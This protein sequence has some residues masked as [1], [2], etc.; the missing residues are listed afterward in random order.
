MTS[1]ADQ[2]DLS[3]T[4][5]HTGSGK[6]ERV[7]TVHYYDH[8]NTQSSSKESQERP[9]APLPPPIYATDN[10]TTNVSYDSAPPRQDQN[11]HYNIPSTLPR[12]S[13][14]AAVLNPTDGKSEDGTG[15]EYISMV[16]NPAHGTKTNSQMVMYI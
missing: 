6:F 13:A 5:Q 16:P 4:A 15:E 9:P 2:R 11:E 14:T 8:I 10:L 7:D 12:P 3:S 1:T